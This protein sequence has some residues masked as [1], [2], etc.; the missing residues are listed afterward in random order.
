M[1]LTAL[2][3]ACTPDFKM[4]LNQVVGYIRVSTDDR[5]SSSFA[6][7]ELRITNH[8]KSNGLELVAIYGDQLSGRDDLRPGLS[9]AINHC[10]KLGAT[11]VCCSVDRLS[12]NIL[13]MQTLLNSKVELFF[14]DQ[15]YANR[16]VLNLFSVM[17][18][19][20]SE[21][22]SSRIVKNLKYRRDVCGQKLGSKNI[23]QVAKLG[24]KQH[25]N[26]CS[27]YRK[28]ILPLVVSLRKEKY[29]L[30]QIADRLNN[31]NI[32]TIR[33]TTWIPVKIHQMLKYSE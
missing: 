7:Q 24:R 16:M 33:G 22:L 27:T 4:N 12:R 23:L 9:A 18:E 6:N 10:Q 17:A 32:K 19:F 30:Q 14:L 25:Q 8:C 3:H 21:Q 5:Q 31:L 20:E 1:L 13:K 15:P 11:L 2:Y 29:T 28:D 26:I